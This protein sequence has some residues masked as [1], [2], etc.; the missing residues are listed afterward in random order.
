M[1]SYLREGAETKIWKKLHHIR[2]M[3]S[4]KRLRRGISVGVLGCMAERVSFGLFEKTGLVDPVV[5]P[6][7][8]KI[9]HG[10]S[11]PTGAV[12]RQRST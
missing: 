8:Y 4:M 7:S 6:D 9:Y 12:G 11:R 1:K 2:K 5:G 10:Y 3:R